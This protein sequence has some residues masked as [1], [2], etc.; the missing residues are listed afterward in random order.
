MLKILYHKPYIINIVD[1]YSNEIVLQDSFSYNICF[2]GPFKFNAI[3]IYICAYVHRHI[4]LPYIHQSLTQC[5]Y[6]RILKRISSR[7]LCR[8]FSCSQYRRNIR[9]SQ[10]MCVYHTLSVD[11]S[12]E[13]PLRCKFCGF[14]FIRVIC[15]QKKH[16]NCASSL[17]VRRLILL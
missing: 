12:Y 5:S 2:S 17:C 15:I 14:R 10:I 16:Q 1:L 9:I 11:I 7:L 4:Y 6:I 8:C 3:Q 13:N